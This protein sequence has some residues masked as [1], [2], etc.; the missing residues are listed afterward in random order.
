MAEPACR[1]LPRLRERV[2]A[3]AESAARELLKLWDLI[4]D[5][6]AELVVPTRAWLPQAPRPAWR[7]E[8]A[9]QFDGFD[10][11]YWTPPMTGI[12]MNPRDAARAVVA[13]RLRNL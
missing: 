10:P 12:V 8:K 4:A 11:D 3:L 6:N 1:T 13:E 5:G 7:I 9:E 2:N